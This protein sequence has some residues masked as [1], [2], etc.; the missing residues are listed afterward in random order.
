MQKMTASACCIVPSVN[1][2]ASGWKRLIPGLDMIVPLLKQD[3][4]LS[5]TMGGAS[6]RGGAGADGAR[7]QDGSIGLYFFFICCSIAKD[8]SLLATEGSMALSERP[9]PVNLRVAR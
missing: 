6:V 3:I 7:R 5:L 9:R 4:R 1:S 8:P 2:I